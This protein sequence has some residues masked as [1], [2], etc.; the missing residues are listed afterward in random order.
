MV[1]DREY[2]EMLKRM[3]RAGARRVAEADEIELEM[4]NEVKMFFDECFSWS[5]TQQV[6]NGKS[7]TDI[8]DSLGITRQ[9]AHKK[10]GK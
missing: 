5:I 8:G 10:Y 6:K 2:F 1:E 4:F 9:A 3:I 7:W